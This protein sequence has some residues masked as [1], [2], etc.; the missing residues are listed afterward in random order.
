MSSKDRDT[1]T[2][3]NQTR[4]RIFGND[5]IYLKRSDDPDEAEHCVED[6]RNH[7]TT[8]H[9]LITDSKFTPHRV[10]R[11]EMQRRETVMLDQSTSHIPYAGGVKHSMA[12]MPWWH[13]KRKS[14][15]MFRYGHAEGVHVVKT[16]MG[17]HMFYRGTFRHDDNSTSGILTAIDYMDI[18]EF[19]KLQ[20]ELARAALSNQ[21]RITFNFNQPRN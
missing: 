15:Y 11:G 1:P 8:L 13:I 17:G 9:R 5:T 21:P 7:P 14:S 6:T 3:L 16:M 20:E 19:H 12:F 18:S 4:S 10:E 2:E